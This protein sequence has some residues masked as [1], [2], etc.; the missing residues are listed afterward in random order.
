MASYRLGRG[1]SAAGAGPAR[2][3]HEVSLFVLFFAVWVDEE[4]KQIGTAL[5]VLAVLGTVCPERREDL[6]VMVKGK[7]IRGRGEEAFVHDSTKVVRA[8]YLSL[9][10]DNAL[11]LRT[12]SQGHPHE[13]IVHRCLESVRRCKY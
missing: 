4:R 2:A 1:V 10:P 13:G 7:D 3:D 9:I 6:L 11:N 12:S 5:V 8:F